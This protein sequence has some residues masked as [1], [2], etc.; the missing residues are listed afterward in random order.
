MPPHSSHILQPL[1]VGCFGPLKQLYGQQIENL[2]QA[3]IT[4]ITKED[5]FPAFFTVFQD[6][7]TAKNIQGGF[8]GAGLVPLDLETV[9]SRLDVK[10]QTPTPERFP[11]TPTPWVSKTPN[12]PIEASS[13]SEFIKKQIAQHQNS[14][15]TSIYDAIDQFSKGLL[16]IM[17]QIALLKSE[18][19]ILQEQNEILSKHCRAK[20]RRLQQGGSMTL[21]EGQDIQTQNDM[22]AQIKEETRQNSGCK[23]RTETK[24]R[25]CGRCGNPGH[26]AQTCQ[27]DVQTSEENDF[28]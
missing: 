28:Q 3:S 16:G 15:P 14:S 13:Q 6:S 22:E 7:F 10:L 12:N 25:R 9:I 18:N 19:R 8:Q 11:E 21:A 2:M 1:D 23:R 5:F 27:E 20:K 4:H 17:H 24:E 26:N